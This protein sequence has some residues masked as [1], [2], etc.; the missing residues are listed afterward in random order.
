MTYLSY[1]Q[2]SVIGHTWTVVKKISYKNDYPIQVTI[3]L[4]GTTE[5]FDLMLV[6]EEA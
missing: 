5:N 3:E 6:Y 1:F 4:L 2:P